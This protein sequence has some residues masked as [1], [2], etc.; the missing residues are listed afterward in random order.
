MK[1]S[2][3]Q[4]PFEDGRKLGGHITWCRNNPNRAATASKITQ[5]L[6]GKKLSTAVKKKISSTI[7]E[8]LSNGLWHN[9]F[10]RSRRQTYAGQ[11]FDGKWEM[12][13]A[14][15]FDVHEISWIRNVKTFPYTYDKP[16]QY[17]PD[18][19]LPDIDC[20]IEVKGWKT[21]KDEAKWSQFSERLLVLAGSDLLALGLPI[22][23]SKDWKSLLRRSRMVNSCPLNSHL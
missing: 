21:P 8:K 18:F 12:Y 13:L 16:R 19:Y 5:G 10:A 7:N 17:T 11:P 23:V 4:L 3:C 22:T 6:L 1:C 2:Y 20:Y 9:S 15:W 14:Q